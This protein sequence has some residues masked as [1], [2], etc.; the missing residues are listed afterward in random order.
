M[1]KSGITR[2]DTELIVDIVRELRSFGVNN[3]R[4]TIRAGVAIARILA[5]QKRRVQGDDIFFQMICRDVLSNDTAKITRGGQ[6][7][8]TQKV[9]E[10]IRKYCGSGKPAKERIKEVQP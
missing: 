7:V 6:P 8:M 10:V 1:K 5:S 2:A 9:E 3:N 4:P